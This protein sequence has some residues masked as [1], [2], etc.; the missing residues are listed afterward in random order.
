MTAMLKHM[1]TTVAP[2]PAAMMNGGAHHPVARTQPD[3]TV[4]M[5][6]LSAPGTHGG[7]LRGGP[8]LLSQ[9][10]P[11]LNLSMNLSQ[12]LNHSHALNVSTLSTSK[13]SLGTSSGVSPG[14][15]G[16]GNIAVN[17]ITM[18][19]PVTQVV[20][21]PKIANGGLHISRGRTTSFSGASALIPAN[22]S[23]FM[24][25]SKEAGI[26]EMLTSLGLLCLVSLLL[27]LLSLIFLLKISPMTN[28]DMRDMR[29]TEQLTI[30]SAD[31][32]VVVYEVTLALCALTLSLN[33]CCLLVC[34]I[35][36]LF[37][38]KLVKSPQGDQR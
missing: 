9:H 37:A 32:Y 12:R 28:A 2:S 30:I 33:L 15:G 16:G 7:R 11:Q 34:A 1:L 17:N 8:N 35:Q 14:G 36:F 29:R 4:M 13:H 20:T 3:G 18:N 23:R 19:G 10:Q 6:D 21:P 31:E 24:T 22:V 26:K 25:R 5:T 27:A 38:V